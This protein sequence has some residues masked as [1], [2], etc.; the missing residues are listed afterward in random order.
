M[1]YQNKPRGMEFNL[2]R[3]YKA[4]KRDFANALAEARKQYELEQLD[5]VQK[6]AEMDMGSFY[7]AIKTRNKKSW[8]P[9]EMRISGV[10][11]RDPDTI[12]SAWYENFKTLAEKTE[13]PLFDTNFE[14]E[15]EASLKDMAENSHYNFDK[16]GDI[17]IR[18]E[19]S[20]DAMKKMNSGKAP[21]LDQLVIEHIRLA[22]D[23]LLDSVVDLFNQILRTEKYPKQFKRGVTITLFKGGKKD[24]LD[25]NSYRDI[26]LTSVL[27]KLFEN[28]LFLRIKHQ[29]RNQFPAPTATRISLRMWEFT[30]RISYNRNSSPLYRKRLRYIRGI[31]RQ[32]KGLQQCVA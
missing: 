32:P 4:G 15:V 27:Q 28:V 11:I 29:H 6:T 17:A 2:Y 13:D 21:G 30:S 7:R 10:I 14:T 19:E 1:D 23:I 31:F 18:K 22:E 20:I 12:R 5:Q 16:V 25:P 26:T 24:R 9:Q 8:K 3:E